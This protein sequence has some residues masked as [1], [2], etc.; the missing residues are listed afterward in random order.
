MTGDDL[1]VLNGDDPLLRTLDGK[2][3]PG[4]LWCG[5]APAPPYAAKEIRQMGA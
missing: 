1:A 3:A 5:A 2:I 4:I